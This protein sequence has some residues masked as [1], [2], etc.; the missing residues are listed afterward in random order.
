MIYFPRF[1]A[2]Q[3]IFLVAELTWAL[4]R[5]KYVC[6]RLSRSDSVPAHA[7]C[8]HWLIN[9]ERVNYFTLDTHE[10]LSSFHYLLPLW[11]LY[12]N[13]SPQHGLI[14]RQ[15]LYFIIFYRMLHR[16]CTCMFFTQIH[17]QHLGL[18]FFFLIQQRIGKGSALLC[19]MTLVAAA[20]PEL[21]ATPA[22]SQNSQVRV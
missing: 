18:Y 1:Y 8:G 14:W 12:I 4:F 9:S 19:Q 22:N 13:V 21:P 20:T 10:Y 7:N 17:I 15:F 11:I 6:F 3:T 5:W 2:L 16:S